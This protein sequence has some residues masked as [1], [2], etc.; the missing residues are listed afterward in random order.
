MVTVQVR[1]LWR[2]M[3]DPKDNT[4]NASGDGTNRKV[5]GGGRAAH[6]P[7]A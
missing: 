6:D 2:L 3:G 5:L 7:R 1:D 4:L